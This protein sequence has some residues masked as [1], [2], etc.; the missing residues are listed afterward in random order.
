MRDHRNHKSTVLAASDRLLFLIPWAHFRAPEAPLRPSRTLSLRNVRADRCYS[1]RGPSPTT[2][3]KL[4]FPFA[5]WGRKA[6]SEG[7]SEG[8]AIIGG[9]WG[10]VALEG[11]GDPMIALLFASLLLLATLVDAGWDRSRP[12]WVRLVVRVVT[13]AALTWLMQLAVGSPLA[14]QLAPACQGN[15]HGLNWSRSDGGCSAPGSPLASS[16]WRWS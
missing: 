5:P 14:P 12:L 6:R 7:L 11:N 3:K 10:T 8:N 15:E 13:F 2:R 16:G 9:Y 4:V 1:S